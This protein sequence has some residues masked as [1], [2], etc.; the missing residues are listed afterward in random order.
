MNC[1]TYAWDQ[2]R[3]YGGHIC[4]RKSQLSVMFPRPKWHPVH[5][6]PHFIHEA[7]DGTITHYV[8]TEA[9][10]QK[11]LEIGLWRSWLDLWSFDGEVKIGE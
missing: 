2:Y 1:L 3:R 5:L 8:P 10:K 11:H 4:M 7:P 6:V 9:T